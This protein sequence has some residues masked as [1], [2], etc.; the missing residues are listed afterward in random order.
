LVYFFCF[1]EATDTS[2]IDA[3]LFYDW[4]AAKDVVGGLLGYCL[5]SVMVFNTA[6]RFGIRAL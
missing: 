2:C 1:F 3:F 4:N 6:V 5:I